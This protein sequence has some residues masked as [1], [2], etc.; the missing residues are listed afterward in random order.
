MDWYALGRPQEMQ[1][2]S[3][4]RHGIRLNTRSTHKGEDGEDGE[5]G[6]CE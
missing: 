5:D 2:Y 4:A 3:Y 6:E 1:T